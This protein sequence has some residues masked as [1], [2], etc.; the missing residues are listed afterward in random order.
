MKEQVENSDPNMAM[1]SYKEEAKKESVV[2]P[3]TLDDCYAFGR[4]NV[5]DGSF[6]STYRVI[7]AMVKNIFGADVPTHKEI[8]NP[9][10]G[11]SALKRDPLD[12]LDA[13]V[14][15]QSKDL[16]A[17]TRLRTYKYTRHNKWFNGEKICKRLDQYKELP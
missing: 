5:L 15:F 14:Y 17:N 9:I 11:K 3:M 10:Y 8:T 2:I 6:G 13:A 16:P 4:G 7:Q 12:S 1:L